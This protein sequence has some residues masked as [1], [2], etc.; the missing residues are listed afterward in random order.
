ML[1]LQAAAVD[2]AAVIEQHR[3]ALAAITVIATTAFS[4][5]FSSPP[6]S[7]PIALHPT[8]VTP[9]SRSRFTWYGN[10]PCP[11]LHETNSRGLLRITTQANPTIEV[12]DCCHQSSGRLTNHALYR[13]AMLHGWSP[14]TQH[15]P[16]QLKA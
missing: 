15:T 11:T 7:L 13:A 5:S 1:I 4:T 10:L 16:T 14:N 9:V 2:A 6:S 12:P 8:G 3:E